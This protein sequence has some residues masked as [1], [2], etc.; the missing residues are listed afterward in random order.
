MKP[1]K[2]IAAVGAAVAIAWQAFGA[3]A[4]PTE[5]TVKSE[6]SNDG[7]GEA[8]LEAESAPSA[9]APQGGH[10]PASNRLP[11]GAAPAHTPATLNH[12]ASLPA[13]PNIALCGFD[14]PDDYNCYHPE[15]FQPV[16]E[17]DDI[18]EDADENDPPAE[19]EPA[20]TLG[21]LMAAIRDHARVNIT[22][23]PLIIQPDQELHLVN[24][25]VIVRTDPAAQAFQTT[26]L[27]YPVEIR[28]EPVSYSWDFGDGSPTLNTTDVGAPYPDH[29]LAH[30]YN[31]PGDYQI[32]MYTY[33]SGSFRIGAGDWYA[34]DGLG[35]TATTSPTLDVQERTTRLTDR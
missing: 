28:A 17:P 13:G 21:Q 10:H 26:L 16:P 14:N 1:L 35:V 33:W 32:T 19:A 27:G 15:M 6:W 4:L 24:L 8:I 20:V 29:T 25:E 18:D 23:A 11:T 22:P 34:I 7:P 31:Q 12:G 5:G 30:S 3:P 2:T 9:S